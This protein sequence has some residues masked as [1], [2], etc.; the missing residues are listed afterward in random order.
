[1]KR[2]TFCLL[3]VLFVS[4]FACAGKQTVRKIETTAYCGCG[5]CCGW[6]R[7]NWKY[8]KLDF[9]NQHVTSGKRKGDVYTGKTAS[10]SKPKEPQPGLFSAD[11]I[12]RPW[13]IPVRIVFFPWLLMPRDGTL[14]ADTK[15]YRF[16]T[17]MY[18]PEYGWGVVEDRG[19][20]IKGP[21]R[22]DLY[23]KS[24]R[25]ALKWGRKTVPVQIKK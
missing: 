21:G 1:M 14:A 9:W 2:A 6:E 10:G 24:H 16:G 11:S 5:K 23:F 4:S 3:M 19:S 12:K 18:I 20:A 15:Y 25:N 8:L 17:R 22:L 7:G 13:M